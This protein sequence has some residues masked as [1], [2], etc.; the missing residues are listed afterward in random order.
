M[1]IFDP[2]ILRRELHQLPELALHEHRTA[3]YILDHL[4]VLNI[5]QVQSNVGGTPGIVAYIRGQEPGPVMALRADMDALPFCIDGQNCA[6]H[7]CGHD[8]H[9][10]MVLSAA[11]RLIGQI[12]RGALK[13]IFQPAEESLAGAPALIQAGVMDDVDILL[14]AHI[15]AQ[16]DVPAGKLCSGVQHTA[17]G[18][19]Y[20]TI[21]GRAAHA[22]RPHLG[23]NAIDTA[24]QIIQGVQ[25]LW[26]DPRLSWSITATQLHG[27][28]GATNTIP[29]HAKIT[30]DIRAQTNELMDDL[31]PKFYRMIECTG[32]AMGAKVTIEDDIFC[33]AAVYTPSLKDEVG[34]VIQTLFG[35]EA[36]HEDSRGGGE[37]FHFYK[38][39]KPSI[40]AAYF[41]VGVGATPGLHLANMDFDD[42]LLMRGTDVM[43][44]MVKRRLG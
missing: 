27:D 16:K 9:C 18:T 5:T 37:D 11:S 43:V 14:G 26:F 38:L 25:S 29:A 3:Q 13:L 24:L 41:G 42:S 22:S 32:Q 7:A 33:P 2:Q 21:E 4:H 36:L 20:V 40:E 6:I 10:A 31:R 44:E 30:F 1:P 12:R 39:H 35:P 34:E 28:S 23:V 17:C 8:G 15:C 19:T